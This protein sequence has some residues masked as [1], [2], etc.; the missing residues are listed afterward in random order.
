MR[1]LGF[2]LEYA[3]EYDFL[4]CESPAEIWFTVYRRLD[5][6]RAQLAEARNFVELFVIF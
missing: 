4:L 2:A 3:D 5:L 6:I 1:A